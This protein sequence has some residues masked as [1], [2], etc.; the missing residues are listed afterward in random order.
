[1]TC[2]DWNAASSVGRYQMA[3]LLRAFAGGVVVTGE[4]AVGHGP[5][6]DDDATGR[7][8][9]AW[10]AQPEASDFLLYKLYTHAAAFARRR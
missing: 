4:E 7:L 1:M 3:R 8:F 2:T 10:C 6:L 5:T 9:A